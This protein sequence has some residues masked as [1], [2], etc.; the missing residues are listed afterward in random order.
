VT[1]EARTLRL[2]PA[3]TAR[4]L[5]EIPA[6]TTLRILETTERWQRVEHN[7]ASG[8]IPR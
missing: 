7:G 3:N 8:W 2:A 6:N 4:A 5:G 1:A